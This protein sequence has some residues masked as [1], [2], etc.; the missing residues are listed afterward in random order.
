MT[1][2]LEDG[3]DVSDE[4]AGDD[5][6]ASIARTLPP[7]LHPLLR[8]PLVIVLGAALAGAAF[9]VLRRLGY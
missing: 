5:L 6:G 1:E 2:E 7:S 8:Y 3:P 9:Y 4:E